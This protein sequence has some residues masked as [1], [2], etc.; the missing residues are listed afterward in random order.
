MRGFKLGS[1]THIVSFP[2]DFVQRFSLNMKILFF[3]CTVL[4]VFASVGKF[5][6]WLNKQTTLINGR[7]YPCQLWL[8]GMMFWFWIRLV[9]SSFVLIFADHANVRTAVY[10]LHRHLCFFVFVRRIFV[11]CESMI[12]FLKLKI[13][14]ALEEIVCLLNCECRLNCNIILF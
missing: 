7:T 4:Q 3:F 10:W 13:I 8:I 2:Y 9:V 1:P 12:F 14:V 6:F 5:V 11:I